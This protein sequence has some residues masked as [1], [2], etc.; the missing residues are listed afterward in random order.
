MTRS[1]RGL[2]DA[3]LADFEAYA[4]TQ[5]F[6]NAQEDGRLVA[7]TAVPVAELRSATGG[8]VRSATSASG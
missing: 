4:A 7:T 8:R 5:A 1:W 2:S 6:A 3:G